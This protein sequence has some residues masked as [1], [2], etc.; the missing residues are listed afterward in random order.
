MKKWTEA[1]LHHFGLQ[2]LYKTIPGYT[3]LVLNLFFEFYFFC[4]YVLLF[5]FLTPLE[6]DLKS[7]FFA[8]SEQQE[9]KE[10]GF[11]L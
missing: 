3:L 11:Y 10:R 8:N 2:I 6:I 9:E 7:K 5:F 4:M 1:N